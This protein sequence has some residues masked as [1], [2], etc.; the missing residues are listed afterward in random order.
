MAVMM[1]A[2]VNCRTHNTKT[3]QEEIRK[4]MFL[5][6]P[7]SRIKQ[8]EVIKEK[9]LERHFKWKEQWR[10]LVIKLKIALELGQ[11]LCRMPNYS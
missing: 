10:K 9:T 8:L 4:E 7:V 2:T 6:Q 11:N 3:I 5:C 1:G